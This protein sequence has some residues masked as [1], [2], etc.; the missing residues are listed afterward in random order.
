MKKLIKFLS[1]LIVL[2]ISSGALSMDKPMKDEERI[3]ANV[4]GNVAVRMKDVKM[5]LALLSEYPVLSGTI[6]APEVVIVTDQSVNRMSE[7]AREDI[8]SSLT[9]YATTLTIDGVPYSAHG[10]Y[11]PDYSGDAIVLTPDQLQKSASLLALL[12]N[13]SPN[14]T[15]SSRSKEEVLALVKTLLSEG[16]YPNVSVREDDITPL[17]FAVRMKSVELVEA[18]LL[19]GANVNAQ[20]AQSEEYCAGETPL[21]WAVCCGNGDI[22]RCL[23]NYGALP[24]IVTEDGI[25]P[26]YVG[27]LLGRD[28]MLPILINAMKTAGVNNDAI[29][30]YINAQRTKKKKSIDVIGQTA[31]FIAVEQENAQSVRILLQLGADPNLARADGMT[32]EQMAIERKNKEILALIHPGLTIHDSQELSARLRQLRNVGDSVRIGEE[33]LLIEDEF[34]QIPTQP[35][36]LNIGNRIVPVGDRIARNAAASPE[37]LCMMVCSFIA[38]LLR[39]RII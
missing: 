28:G 18:L 1:I 8:R 39:D 15:P 31:L 10:P 21:L 9:I 33:I 29:R 37:N 22:V 25:T 32:A 35:A 24:E 34:P 12:K 16:A 26:L 17:H 7:C 19:A 3:V 20:T 11:R 5:V 38:A 23:L 36:V 27:A 13:W 14:W 30:T 6:N 4:W 2:L